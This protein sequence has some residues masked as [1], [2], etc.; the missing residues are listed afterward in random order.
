MNEVIK[1]VAEL[2]KNADS[3]EQLYYYRLHYLGRNGVIVTA[4][5]NLGEYALEDRPARGREIAQAQNKI[6]NILNRKLNELRG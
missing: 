1:N 3:S 6:S 5:K 2:V 4:I